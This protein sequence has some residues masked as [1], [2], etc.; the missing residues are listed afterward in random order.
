M[1][2]KLTTFSTTS[3]SARIL[4]HEYPT[5]K[6]YSLLWELTKTKRIICIVDY[7]KPFGDGYQMRDI[8][9]SSVEIY[10]ETRD[11]GARGISYIYALNKKEFLLQCAKKNLEF[12]L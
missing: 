10:E 9:H 11:I 8:A 6:D 3:Q 5:S 2:G 7:D 4:K 12:L 1:K